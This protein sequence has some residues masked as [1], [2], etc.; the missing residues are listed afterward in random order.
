MTLLNALPWDSY[1]TALLKY[2]DSNV[3]VKLDKAFS[4]VNLLRHLDVPSQ[5]AV[6]AEYQLIQ[7]M[8]RQMSCDEPSILYAD[9]YRL[10]HCIANVCKTHVY[11][12]NSDK[13]VNEAT[14]LS[15]ILLSFEPHDV[16]EFFDF[17]KQQL[18]SFMP[19]VPVQKDVLLRLIKL[20]YRDKL[21]VSANRSYYPLDLSH[22]TV[23]DEF[24]LDALSLCA[25]LRKV[26][27][28]RLQRNYAKIKAT[29]DISELRESGAGWYNV[30]HQLA[31]C[32]LAISYKDFVESSVAEY[33]GEG[34]DELYRAYLAHLPE[35]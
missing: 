23:V 6:I 29:V 27:V 24:F 33:F 35:K 28:R 16:S 12:G 18:C 32:L 17:A 7:R 4:S 19:E 21:L 30:V 3:E 8:E 11:R 1:A 14:V 5:L 22:L 15:T 26:D 13:F 10:L 34:E 9:D 20:G 25:V 31:Y 2:I